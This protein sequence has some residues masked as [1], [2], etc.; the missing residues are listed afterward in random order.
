MSSQNGWRLFLN[1]VAG[2]SAEGEAAKKTIVPNRTV[3][4]QECIVTQCFFRGGKNLSESNGWII[5]SLVLV[6]KY[7]LFTVEVGS[8]SLLSLVWIQGNGYHLYLLTASPPPSRVVVTGEMCALK[9][10]VMKSNALYNFSPA[11]KLMDTISTTCSRWLQMLPSLQ[12]PLFV[13]LKPLTGS[14]QDSHQPHFL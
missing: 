12:K 13:H 11:A 9:L 3:M 4:R 8:S 2:L 14:E 6:N 1:W 7:V 5:F 10:S